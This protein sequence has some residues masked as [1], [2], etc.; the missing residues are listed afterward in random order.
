MKMASTCRALIPAAR[1]QLQAIVLAACCCGFSIDAHATLTLQ[2]RVTTHVEGNKDAQDIRPD[3]TVEERVIVGEHY[4][5]VGSVNNLSVLDFAKRRRYAI[6]P[7]TARY[8]EYSLFDTVG[9][10]VAE[11][12]NRRALAR[13]LA[14]SKID[15]ALSDVVYNEQSL[16]VIAASGSKITETNDG[17]DVVLAIDGKVLLRR[18]VAGTSVS[19]N[20]A[21]GFVKFLR[22][23]AGGHPLVLDRLAAEQRIPQ[24]FTFSYRD[25]GGRQTRHYEILSVTMSAPASYDLAPYTKGSSSTDVVDQLLDRIEQSSPPAYELMRNA[26]KQQTARAF[27]AKRPLDA[28]LGAIELSLMTGQPLAPFTPDETAQLLGDAQVRR[29]NAAIGASGNAALTAAIPVL[30]QAHWDNMEKGHM[31]TL[32]EANDRQ[33]LGQLDVARPM[34]VSVL[35]SNPWLAGAYKDLGDL[36]FREFDMARAWRCWDA[37]RRMA[38]GLSIFSSVNQ[39]E[40]SLLQQH[41]EYF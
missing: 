22:Y 33:A 7:Q 39:L 35:N 29:V 37:G 11:M 9:F 21:A 14:E 28:M 34:F 13:A 40:K 3:T 27:S 32:F 38:P 30:Q 16:S 24:Q 26:M 12:Q 8:V 41:P 5:S 25:A 20:D 10:R 6:D 2:V 17:G 18:S 4:V 15:A 19:A 31:L 36:Q 1:F 23:T